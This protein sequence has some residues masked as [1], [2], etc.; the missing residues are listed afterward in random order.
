MEA[1]AQTA[2]DWASLT[3]RQRRARQ[4]ARMI[5]A[6]GGGAGTVDVVALTDIE[7]ALGVSRTTAGELRQE[8]AELLAGGYEPAALYLPQNGR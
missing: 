4:V 7:A 6:A 2:D 8:A 3:P 1:E 5:L